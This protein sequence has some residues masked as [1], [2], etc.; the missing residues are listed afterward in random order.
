MSKF[1]ILIHAEISKW[2]W[3]TSERFSPLVLWRKRCLPL[4]SQN[5]ATFELVATIGI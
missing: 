2:T 5:Q 4:T 3:L 1:R